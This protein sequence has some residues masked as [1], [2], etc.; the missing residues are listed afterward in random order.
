MTVQA[1][2]DFADPLQPAGPRWRWHLQ[3]P[4]RVWVARTPAEVPALLDEVHAA[5]CGGLWCVGWVAY[6]AAQAWWPRLPWRALPPGSAYALWAAYADAQPWAPQAHSFEAGWRLDSWQRPWTADQARVALATIRQRIE[7]G[8]CYQVN[9]TERR[10]AS[11]CAD[12]P[13]QTPLAL[14]AW[15]D[16]LRDAQP[17]G[18]AMLLEAAPLAVQPWALLSLSPE[19]FVDWH[20]S[21]LTAQPM[22]GT[23]PRQPDPQADRAAA[24][25]LR[26]DP[27]ERA[28]N[29]MIVDLLRNDLGRVARTG[30][31]RVTE[32][33]ALQALPTV[34]QMTS[35]VQAEAR[36]GLRLSELMAAV[37]PCGSVTGAPKGEAMRLIGEL[38][39]DPRGV[40]C[41]ALGLMQ[42]GGRVTLN[43]PIRTLALHGSPQRAW[44]SYGVGS[45]V[46]W[47]SDPEAELRE[48]EAKTQ[49]LHRAAQ[50]FELLESLR[51]QE[52]RPLRWRAHWRRTWAAALAFGW[53]WAERQVRAVRRRW[54]QAVATL[55]RQRPS[56]VHKVRVRLNRA[57][58]VQAEAAPLAPWPHPARVTLARAPLQVADALLVRHKTTLRQHYEAHRAP[59]GYVDVLLYNERGE[60]TEGT[61]ANIAARLD[62]VWVTPPVRCGLLPGVMR[63]QLLRQGRLQERVLTLDDVPRVQAWAW[64]NSVRGWVEVE[65]DPGPS[66]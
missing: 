35:T 24:Q 26:D 58:Q 56:G 27:K 57:G 38:E 45:G 54:L 19:L 3:Q 15:F 36:A 44:V 17:G 64:L 52:G 2:V 39:R 43:V 4:V 46:T 14:R 21:T 51:L 6:E 33:L 29:I 28:E 7:Q 13:A 66:S 25:R 12:D 61:L 47:D 30:S 10:R 55:A 20:G 65:L 63:A 16:R 22:K 40:Y 34:W 32:L 49:L 5:A 11:W 9:L 8:V 1:W 18:Y 31:V 23:A 62:G 60:L 37:F 50:P 41:G 42:P 48:W 59:P 53:P